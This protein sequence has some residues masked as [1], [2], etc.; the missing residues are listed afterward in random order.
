MFDMY[1]AWTPMFCYSFSSWIGLDGR[2]KWL[3]V[4]SIL[5]LSRVSL[6]SG[7]LILYNI[8]LLYRIPDI[9]VKFFC[10]HIQRCC[11]NPN[12]TSTQRLGFTWKWLY[13]TTH[14]NSMSAISQLLLTRFW[15]NFKG[16][17]LWTSRIDS[18]CHGDICPGDINPYQDYLSSYWPD[19]DET[20]KV[21]SCEHLE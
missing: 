14:R 1:N 3:I 7:N 9:L 21:Y 18:D 19:L 8:L 20:L 15:W 13:T 5:K 10:S 11:Q 16:R 4:A 12:L 17:F 2:N 6:V